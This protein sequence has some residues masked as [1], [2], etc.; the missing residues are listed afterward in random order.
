MLLS[1]EKS[2]NNILMN[3]KRPNTEVL[4]Q[5]N[6]HSKKRRC[7]QQACPF[8]A[9]VLNSFSDNRSFS[10]SFHHKSSKVTF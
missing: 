6:S 2:Q 4:S 9:T 5:S 10:E 3:R 1:K 8:K 7:H